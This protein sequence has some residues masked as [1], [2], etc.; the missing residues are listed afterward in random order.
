M[1]LFYSVICL[2][3]FCSVCDVCFCSVL[4]SHVLLSVVVFGV[5][6]HVVVVLWLGWLVFW[7]VMCSWCGTVV[8]FVF[9]VLGW[10]VVVC[11]V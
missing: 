9:V 10:R 2:L 8:V 4:V 11:C 7:F 3:M 5:M 6:L 1:G